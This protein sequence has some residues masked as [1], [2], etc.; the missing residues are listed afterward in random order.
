MEIDLKLVRF[1]NPNL[2]CS[3]KE[4]ILHKNEASTLYVP[5]THTK[6]LYFIPLDKAQQGY[7]IYM[8]MLTPEYGIVFTYFSM[9]DF[10]I[11]PV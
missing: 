9:F 1:D 2:I 4:Y 8:K 3:Y 6:P 10:H 11:L 7:S 5:V